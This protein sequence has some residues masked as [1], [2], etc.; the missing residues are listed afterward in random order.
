MSDKGRAGRIGLFPVFARGRSRTGTV[1]WYDSERGFGYIRPDVEG[2]NVFIHR[3]ALHRRQRRWF[4]TGERVKYKAVSGP[5][6]DYA[7]RLHRM[8]AE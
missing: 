5:H 6:R 4:A 1:V 3:S 7:R 8:A 2:K